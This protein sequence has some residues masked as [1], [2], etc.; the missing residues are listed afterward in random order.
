[1]GIF[2]I[3]LCFRPEKTWIGLAMFILIFILFSLLMYV[4][5]KEWLQQF[6]K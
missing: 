1:M 2:S 5:E 6:K 4:E 3:L